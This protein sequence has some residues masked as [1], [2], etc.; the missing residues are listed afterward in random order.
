[1]CCTDAP[2]NIHFL[3]RHIIPQTYTCLIQF[4][5]LCNTCNICHTGIQVHGTDCVAKRLI[6]LPYRQMCLIIAMPQFI[7]MPFLYGF[8]MFFI[9]VIWFCASFINKKAA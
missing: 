9:K 4:F 7:L 1:M 6:L 8:R 3:F 2:C 5:V